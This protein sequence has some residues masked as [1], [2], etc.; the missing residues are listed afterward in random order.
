ME[1]GSLRCDANVSIR[2]RGASSLSTR[3]EIKN[4][5]SFR[6]VAKA[7]E[8]EI[9]RQAAV[10]ESG[11]E[12]VQE[13]LLWNPDRGETVSM[14]SKEEAHDYRYFPEPDLPP[15]RVGPEWIEEAR[16]ARCRSCPA[17]RRRRSPRSTPCPPTTQPC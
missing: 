13:T 8:H 11:G 3:T 7:L 12:V 5:N 17:E 9:A 15:L 4:L 10:V 6:N 2:P 1:E 14:R 16:G